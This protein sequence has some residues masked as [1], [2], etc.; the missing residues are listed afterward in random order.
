MNR[1][2]SGRHGAD[3]DDRADDDEPGWYDN[4][5]G[6]DTDTDEDEDYEEFVEREF[7]T[8]GRAAG[9]SPFYFWTAIVVIISLCLPLLLLLLQALL[10]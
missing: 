9:L 7:G 8:S 10:S 5:L 6:Y 3:D 4:S 2:R 1:L